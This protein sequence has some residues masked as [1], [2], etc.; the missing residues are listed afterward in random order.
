[1][2]I[3][4][5]RHGDPD[6]SVDGLTPQ[7]ELE[8][9]LL[10]E[11][12]SKL[13]V[14]AF[15]CSPLGRARKTAE[16]TLKKMGRTAETLDW[17]REFEGRVPNPESGH[18]CCWD[19]L[20]AY[21]TAVDDYYDH[22]RWAKVPLMAENG[23]EPLYKAVCDG[24]DALLSRHGYVH[25][26]RHYRVERANGDVIVLFCHFGV[27]GVIL[28]HIFSVSPMILWHN[29]R[30]LPSSVTHLVSEEREEG[31]AQFTALQFGDVSHLYAGGA[32]P[33]FAARFC[34]RYTDSTRH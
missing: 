9:K 16:Y 5:V 32:E 11:R 26:G 24:V 28:S 30:A 22:D 31:I 10:A 4:I 12:L 17:L 1:M 34:E 33:S 21:W 15:Y 13:P 14:A 23:V 3:Y 27:E 8:A 19:R 18:S 20:P 25:E 6:Y 29:F 7:G 2:H